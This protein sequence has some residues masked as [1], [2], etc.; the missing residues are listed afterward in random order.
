MPVLDKL[1]RARQFF[2]SLTLFNF[3]QQYPKTYLV[4]VTITALVGYVY[5]LLFPAGAIFGV[6][7]FYLTVTAPFSGQTLL[8]A[9]TWASVTLLCAGIS[10]GIATIRFKEV[11][12]IRLKRENA[13]LIFNKLEEIQEVI[14]WPTIHSVVLS[15]RFELTI[16][17]TPMWSL[18]FWSRNTLVIGYPF[19]QT[20]SP[21]YFDCALTRKL[22][23]Y[24]KRR[25]LFYN[26]LSYLRT[27][28]EMYPD[29]FKQ[30][31]KVGDQLSYWFFT[32]YGRFYRQL[33][34]YVTQTDE[35]Y[36]DGLALNYLNDRDVFKTAESIRLVQFFLNEHF[37][38]KLNELLARG[39]VRP[40]Q[41]KPYEHLSK[42]TLQMLK[43]ARV[44]H[45]LKMLSLET[46]YEGS[47][48]A[49]FAK[50]MHSMGYGKMIAPNV[51]DRTA[52]QYYFGPGN[53][54]L[55][56]HMNKVWAAQTTQQIAQANK[57]SKT[58]N[59]GAMV[60][61]RLTVAF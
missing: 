14:K 58:K 28:W 2:R 22:L 57:K 55:V 44:N 47:H 61:Q 37:W 17:K 25:N 21:E 38:P 4:I 56:Q 42:A 19:M 18:P 40:E 13:Q 26:W 9:L 36:A 15:R 20:L 41:I 60:Q 3:S 46:A 23:Q 27:T 29:S 35:L 32:I 10:H 50:R 43:S 11:E 31:N 7:Q 49:P 48:E 24:G 39:A 12:G 52:A 54:K 59:K 5:L 33:A 8:T 53:I 45:W 34:L 51:S 6:Y 30:R 1:A 16:Q